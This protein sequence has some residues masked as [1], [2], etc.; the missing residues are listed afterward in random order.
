[1]YREGGRSG[2]LGFMW[3]VDV[4]VE[5]RSFSPNHIDVKVGEINA[6]RFTGFFGHPEE[7]HK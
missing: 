2:S 3:E 6:W 4:S 5:L 7:G 1:M